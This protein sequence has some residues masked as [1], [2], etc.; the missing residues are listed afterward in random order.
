MTVRLALFFIE[1]LL[2]THRSFNEFPQHHRDCVKQT[3]AF[4]Y[5]EL[6]F[7]RA[8]VDRR[9][10]S[11]DLPRI[12]AINARNEAL[13]QGP[14]SHYEKLVENTYKQKHIMK[15]ALAGEG[16]TAEQNRSFRSNRN[17]SR[18]N[19]NNSRNNNNFRDAGNS[20]SGNSRNSNGK[21]DNG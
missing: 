3:T 16:R 9:I 13:G 1:E 14:A 15:Q 11:K 6:T 10:K 18:N 2:K 7:F 5:G 17:K 12:M 4:I 21:T 19:S 20:R 8:S